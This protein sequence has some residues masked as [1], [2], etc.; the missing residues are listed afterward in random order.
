MT[1]VVKVTS[2]VPFPELS[3]SEIQDFPRT[4]PRNEE[5]KEYEVCPICGEQVLKGTMQEHMV[6]C[7]DDY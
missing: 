7:L 6:K 4:P 2:H 5:K 3:P 1:N